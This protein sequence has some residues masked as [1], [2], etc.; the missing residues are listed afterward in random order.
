MVKEGIDNMEE[1]LVI[2]HDIKKVDTNGV[3]SIVL[4]LQCVIETNKSVNF[5]SELKDE[6]TYS[7]NIAV[8]TERIEKFKKHCKERAEILGCGVFV[9]K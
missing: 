9:W 8:I 6:E 3:E 5:V 4:S 1:T 2:N 7:E